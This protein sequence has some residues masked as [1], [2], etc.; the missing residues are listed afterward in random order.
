MHG[1]KKNFKGGRVQRLFVI[2]RGV[3]GIVLVILLRD[4]KEIE[5]CPP[6]PHLCMCAVN[7][8]YL[9]GH[10]IINMLLTW[11]FS[12]PRETHFT[13]IGKF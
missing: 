4:F 10:I 1:S 7:T 6:P 2:A 9:K 11:I 8:Q 12:V 13:I 5:F 3:W